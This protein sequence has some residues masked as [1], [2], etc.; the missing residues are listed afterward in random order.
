MNIGA[1]IGIIIFSIIFGTL[2]IMFLVCGVDKK[3]KIGGAVDCLLIGVIM[4]S[5]IYF[6]GTTKAKIWNSGYCECGT[7]WE[8]R[9]TTKSKHGQ[10]TK[11]YVCPNCHIEIEQ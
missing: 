10:V 1:L 4:F 5:G 2:A 8:L 6:E 11:Y 3:H 9:G 7:H